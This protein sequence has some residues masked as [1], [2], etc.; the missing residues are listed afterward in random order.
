LVRS[1]KSI[2]EHRT[3]LESTHDSPTAAGTAINRIE[4]KKD[5]LQI[6][7]DLVPLLADHLD[8]RSGARLTITRFVPL[9]LKRRGVELRIVIEGEA[10]S[11]SEVDSALL[12]AIA[13]AHRWFN[14]LASNRARDTLE[15][16]KRE[17]LRASYVRRLIPYAFLAPSIVEAICEGGQPPDLTVERLRRRAEL[18]CH[19]A[20]QYRVLGL[21]ERFS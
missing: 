10:A 7:L 16:A 6:T 1:L 17:G 9:R 15:I 21:G 14:D 13:R 20:E 5:G 12:Q 11:N 3:Q 2:D 4:L 18:P 8:D 19:W